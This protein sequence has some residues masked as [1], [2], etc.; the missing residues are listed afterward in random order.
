MFSVCATT[1]PFSST[2]PF[3]AQVN[4]VIDNRTNQSYI[5]VSASW[6]GRSQFN[7]LASLL[8]EYKVTPS[9]VNCTVNHHLETCTYEVPWPN[10]SIPTINGNMTSIPNTTAYNLS[11]IVNSP[12]SYVHYIEFDITEGGRIESMQMNGIMIN[13]NKPKFT[14]VFRSDKPW[15]LTAFVYPFVGPPISDLKFLMKSCI[16]D[17]SYATEIENLINKL[18]KWVAIQ[19]ESSN[20]ITVIT[21]QKRQVGKPF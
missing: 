19:G 20:L 8:K 11:M 17:F 7:S 2:L 18:P 6:V 16:D 13:Q 15:T 9:P 1:F 21:E 14:F 5:S 4:H 12:D 3:N 10:I